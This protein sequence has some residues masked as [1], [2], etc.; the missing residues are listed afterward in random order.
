[1]VISQ[2]AVYCLAASKSR[3]ADS[4]LGRWLRALARPEPVIELGAHVAFA[5]VADAAPPVVPTA[6]PTPD[7]PDATLASDPGDPPLTATERRAR[8]AALRGLFLARQRRFAAAEGAFAEAIRLDPALDLA[9]VP[10]FWDL[11]RSAHEAVVR[12]YDE[13]GQGRRAAILAAR[14]HERFRPRLVPRPLARRDAP[15]PTP[16]GTV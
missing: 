14:L 6:P 13:G 4:V 9:T 12:V 3:L 7:P 1:M 8:A 15:A 11:E 5:A 10:T 16:A 2:P